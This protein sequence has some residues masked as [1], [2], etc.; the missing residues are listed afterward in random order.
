MIIRRADRR[1]IDG[2][3]KLLAQVLEVHHIGRPD[4]FKSGT[5]K[6]TDDELI[7]IIEDI[8]TPVFVAVSDEGSIIG[9]CFTVMKQY[10]GDNIMNDIK[11]LYIDDL[12]IDEDYRGE[13]IGT[14][15]YEYVLDFARKEGCYNLT[16]NVWSCNRPAQ[17]FYEAQGLV[18]QKMCMEKIL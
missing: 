13:R 7:G 4:L 18:P 8:G 15:L 16:L 2:I 17:K 6:Y 12:C 14:S 5:K 1:D 9:H 3:N 10:A 11:S